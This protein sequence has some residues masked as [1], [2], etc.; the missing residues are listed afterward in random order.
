M[1]KQFELANTLN[2][3]FCFVVL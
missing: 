3:I 2:F 1:N